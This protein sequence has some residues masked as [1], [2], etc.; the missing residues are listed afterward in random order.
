[1][2]ATGGMLQW[3]RETVRRIPK[4][5][6]STYGD[7]ARAAGFPGAA[8]QVVWALRAASAGLPWHRVVGA[9]G[10]IR[11]PG[12]HGFEQRTRLAAEGVRFR[13]DRIPLSEFGFRYPSTR[14]KQSPKP[15]RQARGSRPL[16]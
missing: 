14:R 13:G 16:I 5:K 8:R 12:E 7:V 3:M 4:G 10:R 11:L 9:G 15:K 2:A 1:M 6:V